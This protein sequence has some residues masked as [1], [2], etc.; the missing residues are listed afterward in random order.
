MLTK[1]IMQ[2]ATLLFLN[3]EHKAC[4]KQHKAGKGHKAVVCKKR[5]LFGIARGGI[6]PDGKRGYKK[7]L[8]L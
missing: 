7:D 3:H 2:E 1:V 4:G 5:Q 8:K 6:A